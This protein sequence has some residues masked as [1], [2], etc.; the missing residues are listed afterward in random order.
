MTRLLTTNKLSGLGSA[1]LFHKLTYK[2][3]CGGAPGCKLYLL[4]KEKPNEHNQK[5]VCAREG[6]AAAGTGSLPLTRASWLGGMRDGLELKAGS[7]TPGGALWF[8]KPM[9]SELSLGLPNGETRV[10]KL[11]SP[12]PHWPPSQSIS[13]QQPE[14]LS[15]KA[16]LIMPRPLWPN[17]SWE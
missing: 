8:H 7:Q 5:Y 2:N 1:L 14:G 15:Y 4:E 9:G 16:N 13:T 3:P 6:S 10:P 17:S 12:N 11:V